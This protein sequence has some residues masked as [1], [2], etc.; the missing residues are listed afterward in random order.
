MKPCEVCL[1]VKSFSDFKLYPLNADG[2]YKWCDPCRKAYFR[3]YARKRYVSANGIPR[4][5]NKSKLP[6]LYAPTELQA[7]T[8]ILW[9]PDLK[10]SFD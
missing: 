3:E 5:Y 4:H 1:E 6:K 7:P 9:S 2:L 10:V 8:P